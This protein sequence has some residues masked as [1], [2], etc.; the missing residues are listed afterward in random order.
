V[1]RRHVDRHD[2][3]PR[4]R[5]LLLALVGALYDAQRGCAVIL[6]EHGTVWI[7]TADRLFTER[8]PLGSLESETELSRLIFTLRKMEKAA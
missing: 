1:T 7:D 2:P 6:G 4:E 8:I 3:N 5:A